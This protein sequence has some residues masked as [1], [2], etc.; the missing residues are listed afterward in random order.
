M[1]S[2]TFEMLFVIGVVASMIV[3]IVKQFIRIGKPIPDA[4]L[5][6]GVYVVSFL[7]ALAFTPLVL[8]AFP[9]YVDLPTFIPLLITYLGAL[10]VVI[11]APV[12]LAALIYQALLKRIMDGLG[13]RARI[14]F[15]RG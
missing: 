12:G 9:V 5:T 1:M 14:L 4:W 8:P 10:V 2:L 3:W 15:A 11:S 6:V 13:D 7:L